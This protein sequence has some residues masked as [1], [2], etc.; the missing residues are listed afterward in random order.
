VRLSPVDERRSHVLPP[1]QPPVPP[2]CPPACHVRVARE[3][4]R[5]RRELSLYDV[6]FFSPRAH[7]L[8]TKIRRRAS[9]R[10]RF[11]RPPVAAASDERSGH[12]IVKIHY[13]ARECLAVPLGPP[14]CSSSAIASMRT[15]I[16][17]GKARISENRTVSPIDPDTPR[18]LLTGDRSRVSSSSESE[19]AERTRARG[20]H[21]AAAVYHAVAGTGGTTNRRLPNLLLVI[22]RLFIQ[23][24]AD[25][26]GGFSML[27]R[28]AGAMNKLLPG[29]R[30]PVLSVLQGPRSL[31]SMIP[32]AI[33]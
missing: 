5:K 14:I 12:P 13:E 2:P 33:T 10:G 30:A 28:L 17:R 23:M 21:L 3:D 26:R 7:R 15:R 22:D 8:V 27:G 11:L 1:S 6:D 16:R 29:A 18:G 19:R 25:Y 32:G 20:L 31:R 4:R 9:A 24:N